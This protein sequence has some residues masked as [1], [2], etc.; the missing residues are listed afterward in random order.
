MTDREPLAPAEALRP[1]L[2]QSL[3]AAPD[4]DA[5]SNALLDSVSRGDGLSMSVT[6]VTC[7]STR[8]SATDTPPG[9]PVRS[10]LA[11]LP[12]DL[13]S[14]S[15]PPRNAIDTISPSE[16][17]A[18]T[19]A[20]G[21]PDLFVIH[22]AELAAGE[23]VIADIARFAPERILILSPDPVAADRL[24]E[25]LAHAE[26]GVVRA[27]A[28]DENPIRP[29]PVVAKLTSFALGSAKVESLRREAAA[30]VSAT[31]TRLVALDRLTALDSEI[32]EL[33]AQRASL[34]RIIHNRNESPEL[35]DMGAELA[36]LRRRHAEALAAAQK[37][38][39]FF[40][41]LF[42]PSK[43]AGPQAEEIEKRIHVLEAER[44][45]FAKSRDDGIRAEIAGKCSCMDTRL[46]E[47]VG[48]RER[49]RTEGGSISRD[50]AERELTAAR[51]R[52]VDLESPDLIRRLLAPLR[53]VV[54]TPGSL[55]VDPVFERAAE[56]SQPFAL[57]VL[58]RCEELTEADFTRLAALAGRW[59]LVGDVIHP[60]E[61]KSHSNG[62]GKS[63]R[64]G[65]AREPGFAARLARLLDREMWAFDADR[66]VCR[67]S[68]PVATGTRPAL[69]REPLLD[70]PEIE[71]RFAAD[72]SG[73]PVLAEVA[74]PAA[75]TIADAKSFLFH[76]LG[77]VLLQPCGAMRWDHSPSA[78][79]A[80]W[81]AAEHPA[82]AVWIDLE[83][84]VREKVAGTG[85]VAFTA[86][87]AFDPTSGWDNEKA[88]LWL[89][90]HLSRESAGRF[91][92][93]SSKRFC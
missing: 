7:P 87:V 5:N 14:F 17:H 48:E 32:A 55:E 69:T 29:S 37:K 31:E 85:L 12:A 11:R 70:R 91:A 51:E 63:G 33:T 6:L 36:K 66:L 41:R 27:L 93:I 82:S 74:F 84:G 62:N 77:E 79:S 10:W 30:A 89:A 46:V 68:H 57:L 81:P 71:L 45:A 1:M 15:P 18:A 50:A 67:L 58:D 16:V 23:R 40:A 78:L 73:E 38:P 72:S 4:G 39:G 24:T 47:L 54:G 75:T 59:V 76:Q 42:G 28:D 83:P 43:P 53:V 34:V 19:R 20:A 88:E 26:G 22:A 3:A 2:K 9:D 65:R 52:L 44:A 49:A 80:C 35:E 25:R 21:C 90:K 61:S 56:D 60:D 86:A 13:P 8:F 64:N 92:N